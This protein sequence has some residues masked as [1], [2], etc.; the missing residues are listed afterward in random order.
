MGTQFGF[1][2]MFGLGVKGCEWFSP[3]YTLSQNK[4][5]VSLLIWEAGMVTLGSGI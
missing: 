4:R 1:K 2:T 3:S 5:S